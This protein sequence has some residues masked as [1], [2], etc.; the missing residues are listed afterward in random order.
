MTLR[1]P[2]VVDAAA[3]AVVGVVAAAEVVEVAVVVESEAVSVAVIAEGQ[4]WRA[5]DPTEDWW[6]LMGSVN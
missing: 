4:L 5:E 1:Q 6:Q 2:A 3:A